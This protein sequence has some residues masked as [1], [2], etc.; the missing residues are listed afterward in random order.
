MWYFEGYTERLRDK[1]PAHRHELDCYAR[2]GNGRTTYVEQGIHF[3]LDFEHVYDHLDSDEQESEDQEPPYWDSTA[4]I[5][6]CEST[7]DLVDFRASQTPVKN[8]LDR[9]TCVCFASLAVIEAMLKRDTNKT[10][11]LSEQYANWLF[12]KNQNRN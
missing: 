3:P 2:D 9:G 7:S 6:S 12:M 11:D 1:R 10:I 8:Q 5:P 4:N